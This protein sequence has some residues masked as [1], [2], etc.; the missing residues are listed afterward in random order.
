MAE[1]AA[2]DVARRVVMP[3]FGGYKFGAT[4]DKVVK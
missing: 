2:R 1:V 4:A 3:R